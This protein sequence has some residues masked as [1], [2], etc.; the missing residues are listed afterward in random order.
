MDADVTTALAALKTNPDSAEALSKLQK[1]ADELGEAK[2]WEEAANLYETALKTARRGTGEQTLLVALG[3]VYW[4]RL[5]KMEEAEGIFRR[6]RKADPRAPEVLAFYRAFHTARNEIPQLLN[7][8]TQALRAETDAA[9]QTQLSVEMAKLAE[10]E[11]R[12]IEKAIDIWKSVLRK[13]PNREDA[14]EA[15]HR[16]YARAEKWNALLELL[17][18]RLERLPDDAV[19]EKVALHEEM[20]PIYRDRMKLDPMVQSAYLAIRSLKPNHQPTLEALTEWFEKKSRWA[21][22]VDVLSSRAE[23]ATEPAEKVAFYR[24]VAALWAEKL[25][26]PQNA[27]DAY[28][29]ILQ[30]EPEDAAT[31]AALVDLYTKGRKWRS[32]VDLHRRLLASL[33]VGEKRPRLVEMARLASDKLSDEKQAIELW[34][35]VLELDENDAEALAALGGL[36]EKE[37]SWAPLA[38]V[39]GRQAKLMADDAAL[40]GLLE[41]RGLLLAER[42]GALE[43]AARDLERVHA[44]APDNHKVF[45]VL[46]ELYGK[47]NDYAAL[48]TLYARRDQWSELCDV[49]TDLAEGLSDS[50]AAVALRERVAQVAIEKLNQPERA[51]KSYERIVGI[52]PENRRAVDALAGLYRNTEKWSRLLETYEQ[53]LG[54]GEG[55]AQEAGGKRKRKDGEGER[56]PLPV[57]EQLTL[58]AEARRLCEEKLGSKALAFK[59]GLRGLELAPGDVA[60]FSEVERLG[61]DGEEWEALSDLYG[62]RLKLGTEGAERATLLRKALVLATG[63]TKR[64]AEARRLAEE[65]L[66]VAPGDDEAESALQQLF[67]AEEKWPEVVEVMHRRQAKLASTGGSTLS[68]A[69]LLVA[70]SKVEE[71]K[72]GRSETAQSTLRAALRLDPGN[73]KVLAALA[74]VSEHRGDHAGLAEVLEQQAAQAA[75]ADRLSLLLRL[76][77]LQEQRLGDR[78]AARATYTRALAEGPDVPEVIA[79]LERAFD[80]DGLP[81]DEV[82]PIASHLARY[83]EATEKYDRWTEVLQRLSGLARDPAQRLKYLHKLADIYEGPAADRAAAYQPALQI[84]ELDPADDGN[85]ARLLRLSAETGKQDDLVAAFYRV[86]AHTHEGASR[87]KLLGHLAELEEKH[88]GHEPK[89]EKAYRELLAID[90][91][92]DK[93]L[94]ALTKLLREGERWADLR[95]LLDARV[96]RAEVKDQLALYG[97]IAEIDETLLGDREHAVGVFEKQ[98]ELE[99]GNLAHYHGLER[100]LTALGRWNQLADV[101]AREAALVPRADQEAIIL[102]RV[103]VLTD[104][105]GAF[106]DAL[107]ILGDIL[108][109]DP[110]HDDARRAV[111]RLLRKPKAK[112]RAAT[113]LG[114]LYNRAGNWEGLVEVL[115]I[116][117]ASLSG[118]KAVAALAKVAEIQETKLADEASALATWQSVLDMDPGNR[119]ALAAVER[120]ASMLE[121]PSALVDL[122]L[123]IAAKKDADDLRGRAESLTRAARLCVSS[124]GDRARAAQIWQQVL[125][126]D[127]ASH[128]MGRPAAEALEAL[129]PQ[130]GEYARLVEILQAKLEWEDR[131][132]ERAELLVRIADLHDKALGNAEAAVD[133]LRHAFESTPDDPKLLDRIE[134]VFEARGEWRDLIV[135]LERRMALAVGNKARRALRWRIAEIQ[136]QKLEDLDEAIATVSANLDEVGGE[137]KALDVLERLYEKKEAHGSRLEV[138]ERRLTLTE[139][140]EE[141]ITWLRRAAAL[142]AGPLEQPTDAL[143]KWREILTLAPED[144]GTIDCIET[145]LAHDDLELRR[146]GAETLETVY[147]LR[148]DWPSLARVLEIYVAVEDDRRARMRHWMRLA[149]LRRDQLSDDVGALAAFGDAIRDALGEDE[150]TELLDTYEQLGQKLGKIPE[151]VRLFEEVEPD[152]LREDVKLRIERRIATYARERGDLGT[153]AERYLSILDQA[154]DDDEALAGLE[155]I[156]RTQGDHDRLYE[157]VLRRAELALDAP[158][159]EL[160]LRVEAGALAV[161]LERADDAITAYERA[162]EL[163][164]QNRDVIAALQGLYEQT[165]RWVDLRELLERRLSAKLTSSEAIEIH[166]R[167]ARLEIDELGNFVAA[168]EHLRQVFHRDPDHVAAIGMAETLLQEPESVMDAAALLEPVYVKRNAWD[169]LVAID[170]ARRDQLDDPTARVVYTRRIARVY[171]E[172]VEDLGKA[173]EW[174]GKLFLEVP[175]ERAVQEQLLRLAPKLDRWRELATLLDD[176]LYDELSEAPEVLANVKLAAE[177]WDKHLEDR[178][179]ARKHYRRYLDAQPGNA[180]AVTLFEQALERWE[181]WGDLLDL[182]DDEIT[183]A[184]NTAARVALLKRS[185]RVAEQK[186]GDRDRAARTLRNLL[187]EAPH[188]RQAADEMERLYREDERWGDLADHLIWRLEV[189]TD[190]GTRRQIQLRLAALYAD[191]LA[192]VETAL[193]MYG[194]VLASDPHNAPAR[195]AL[196][197]L[198][199]DPGLRLSAAT[200]LEPCYR[201]L[202]AWDRLVPVLTIRLEDGDEPGEQLL[203]LQEIAVLEE[204]LGHND[205]A[206]EARGRVWL[207][208]VANEGALASLEAAVPAARA[209]PRFVELLLEGSESALDP[210][211]QGRLLGKAAMVLETHVGDRARAIETWR[212]ALEANPENENAFVTLER[213]LETDGRTAELVG[214]LEKHADAAL[215]GNNRLRLTRRVARLAEGELADAGRAIAAWNQVLDLADG[216]TEALESLARLFESAERWPALAEVYQRQIDASQD[217][218]QARALRFALAALLEMRL[219]DAAE[220]AACLR[221]V[222]DEFPGDAEALDGLDRLYTREGQNLELLEILDR[223]AQVATSPADADAFAFRAAAL[224]HKDLSDLH[225]AIERYQRIVERTPAFKPAREALWNLATDEDARPAAIAAL[226]PLLRAQGAHAELIDLL[227]IK[228]QSETSPAARIA[229]LSEMAGIE[230]HVRSDLVKAFALW[231]RAFKEDSADEEVRESLERVAQA[232]GDHARLAKIYEEQLDEVYDTDLQRQLALRLVDLYELQL[233]DPDKAL[234]ALRKALELGGGDELAVLGRMEALLRQRAKWPELSEI[235]QKSAEASLDPSEQAQ[236]L[237]ALGQVR[238]ERLSDRRGAFEAFRDALERAPSHAEALAALR[239]L[240]RHEELRADVIDVLEPLAE[241]RGDHAERVTLYEQRAALADDEGRGGRLVAARGRRGRGRAARS[242][243]GADRLRKGLGP[244][245]REPRVCGRR[246]QGGGGT[247]RPRPRASSR[248]LLGKSAAAPWWTWPFGL[249]SS[250]RVLR[251]HPRQGR[252]KPCTRRSWPRTARMPSL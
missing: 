79:G 159:A 33:P 107:D 219:D 66:A 86:L 138:L 209:F 122:H 25:G 200:Q 236:A 176:Y 193:D 30:L 77:N 202:Q 195:T 56:A 84:F 116:R 191:P 45:R 225:G 16:L 63:K 213:L 184:E 154:P 115:Q 90:P 186:L 8:F 248:R 233:R 118:A 78:A 128:E 72:L 164:P 126:L 23:V 32:L 114:P 228:A 211:L 42:L 198:L 62:R 207:E 92:H 146:Q 110:D 252:R 201:E 75:G 49:M 204:R 194:Q 208:D 163:S 187:D 144:A 224:V 7:V 230:E 11:P 134:P 244:G 199:S 93:A 59:W 135:V 229:V 83:Y 166:E 197:G 104:K 171:E 123:E 245:S 226:E 210:D 26:K 161:K 109:A 80:D 227:E 46:R 160:G 215:D 124:L 38:E 169:R 190:A 223:R 1:T 51:I 27:A 35:E 34:N 29:K 188:D 108:K 57:P 179:A 21:D 153:A 101:L 189:E 48:E 47:L 113:V 167:M 143:E 9:A 6:A 168:V 22:L 237:A 127:P 173:F 133:C 100:L 141:R 137:K 14:F 53:R 94:S 17:K 185:A 106:D 88:P 13:Q 131:P 73:P 149:T 177:I 119:D 178:D 172:N 249:P 182:I 91:G 152:V 155:G 31:T 39:L 206:L 214:V 70:A 55:V 222:L 37:R 52:E 74:R 239:N 238:L 181:A 82:E 81:A 36:Y 102:R 156:Y 250:S 19:E 3:N 2:T 5:S 158:A 150:I 217:V 203:L 125:D 43:A 139:G 69:E 50:K 241:A 40:A 132:Q 243:P 170:E 147:E 64:P 87:A 41:R 98:L 242:V 129:Y 68:Q 121:R 231:V 130:I 103:E 220:A 60:L 12:T 165:E 112:Q 136:E 142:L 89:A 148:S 234:A 105:I 218:Q 111:E 95:D 61:R 85:L 15:L 157:L 18:E 192:N 216:D 246:G 71:E 221:H 240:M 235:L 175:T 20:V 65:L 212:R 174:Y 58:M 117:R 162:L 96:A 180:K 120:L 54:S 76:A 247:P 196:E 140:S 205:R 24:R 99:P 44:L 28:E 151:V 97:Q 251:T 183:R 67:A 4:K 145:L 232:R 10:A